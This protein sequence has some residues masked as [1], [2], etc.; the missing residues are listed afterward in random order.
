MQKFHTEIYRGLCVTYYVTEQGQFLAES[1][2]NIASLITDTFQE[3][4]KSIHNT[5]DDMF[6]ATP[7]TYKELAHLLTEA[8]DWED[9]KP[10]L[11]EVICR[12]Y[13]SKFIEATIN[14]LTKENSKD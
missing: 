12:Q 14:N 6:L 13:V 10:V 4:R 7:L 2:G 8:L 3:C 9:N 1:S 5:I 11:E